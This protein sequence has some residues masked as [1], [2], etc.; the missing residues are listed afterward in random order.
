MILRNFDE[1]LEAAKKRPPQRVAVAAAHDLSLLE[2]V[3]EAMQ[4]GLARPIL[5]GDAERIRGLGASIGLHVQQMNIVDV[6]D[7]IRAAREAARMAR[8][9]EADVVMKGHIHSDDFLRAILDR[10]IGLRTG[11]IM[12]HIF[13]FEMPDRDR[14]L[15]VT[16]CAMNIAP[17][18]T[19]KA[20]IILNAVYLA[21]LFGYERPKVGVV[22]AVELVNPAMPATL[23]AAALAKMS[24][25]G[26]FPDCIIDGPFGFDNVI[27]LAAARIKGIE[28]PVAGRADIV[29]VPDIEAGNILAKAFAHLVRGRLAG[30]VVGASAPVV[31]TS[32][33]D[34]AESKFF[35]IACAA[36]MAELSRTEKV[37]VG[38]V[39]Y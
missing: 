36:L 21:R 25:R 32:R 14:L 3:K 31:L 24:E 12:S 15:F 5:V 37:K 20:Q 10:E 26:Q 39:H 34:S 35:S 7:E 17:D 11:V 19:Q 8:E 2:A 29:L 9:G 33:A 22:A 6:P 4:Q 30:V 38:K 13:I 23:E 27:S 16:D 1:V 28:S 18:L